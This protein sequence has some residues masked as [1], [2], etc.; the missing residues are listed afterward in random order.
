MAVTLIAKLRARWRWL[1]I[2][3]ALLLLWALAG[4]VLAPVLI[5]SALV[6]Y[7]R[8]TLHRPFSVGVIR[9]NP[10][11]FT[12]EIHDLNLRRA[13]DEGPL[14]SFKSLHVDAEPLASLLHRAWTLQE[15]RIEQAQV[16]AY[17]D[18]HGELN[19]ANLVPPSPPSPQPETPSPT[20][21]VRIGT[22][23]LVDGR[24]SVDDRSGNRRV[25]MHLSPIG[26]TL[27]DFRTAADH[28]SAYRLEALSSDGERFAWSGQFTVQPLAS[29]GSFELAG[30]HAATIAQFIGDALPISL[31]GGTLDLQG[32]Y[33]AA[34]SHGLDVKVQLPM[35]AVHGLGLL[36][37]GSPETQPWVQLPT[38][39]LRD[40]TLSLADQSVRVRQVRLADTHVRAWRERDGSINLDRLAGSDAASTPARAESSQPAMPWN[41]AVDAITVSSAQVDFEDRTLSP[42]GTLRFA[43]VNIGLQGYT[44]AGNQPLRF[45]VDIGLDGRGQLKALGSGTLE[46]LQADAQVT[47]S[48]L[49]LPQ[50]QPWISAATRVAINDGLFRLQGH[51]ELKAGKGTAP[52]ALAFK[53]GLGIDRLA[54]RD[55]V[56]HE[57]LVAWKQL[58]VNG[59]D[60]RSSPER[61]R[62]DTVRLRGADSRVLIAKDGTL[63]LARALSS[64]GTP[65]TAPPA[66]ADE[67][68]DAEVDAAGSDATAVAAVAAAPAPA[69]TAAEPAG[70]AGAMPISIGKVLLEDASVNFSDH[71]VEPDFSATIVGL[72]GSVSGL[73]SEPASHAKVELSGSVDRYAPVRISGEV[74]LLAADVFSDVSVQFSNIELTTFNPYSGKFAGYNIAKGKLSTAL[75]YRVDK[76]Q[77]LAEHHVIIDQMEFGAATNSKDA[78]PLPVKLAVALLKDRKGV[79]DLK[80]PVTGSLDDPKFRIAPIVWKMLRGLVRKVVTAPFAL[81][82]SLFG[83]GPDLQ[84]VQFAPGSAQLTDADRTRLAQLTR[85]LA[86]RP[87]LKL[88]IPLQTLCPED[89]PALEAANFEKAVA[90]ALPATTNGEPPPARLALLAAL[91]Q[92]QLGTRPQY[93]PEATP[94]PPGKNAPS[95]E[96]QAAR[97]ATNAVQ[98]AWLESQLRP[99][100]AADAIQRDALARTRAE[101]VRDAVAGDGS[102]DAARVFLTARAVAAGPPG[103]ARM[104]LK[105]Q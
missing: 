17:I 11:T 75:R 31:L 67:E 50:L 103:E 18:E 32:N 76:R 65:I 58:D 57:H 41:V 70:E 12:L 20:P 84:Y 74:N 7:A 25:Q 9:F 61:L 44:L 24:V 34:Y 8:D 86:E 73:S 69:T 4:F 89:T 55:A 26:F 77:L 93:P 36:P 43:P 53:G 100:F 79:I 63:N 16:E 27:H 54:T 15:L 19:L 96:A 6:S 66:Q 5:R 48:A 51:A 98:V 60:Y 94:A 33:Q 78:V 40:T 38:L 72:S 81:L 92:K 105:L 59:I 101:A 35:V 3:A 83:G 97:D 29:R 10:F 82:G 64:P 46:P 22:L 23:A 52:P 62:V 37:A 102:V 21:S 95:A 42:A 47:V 1:A 90:A 28:E 88:D 71:A 2:A 87:Q 80:L 104:E 45:D 39:E 49:A 85:A 14:L 99:R 30:L 68:D 13:R 56:A 91:Y